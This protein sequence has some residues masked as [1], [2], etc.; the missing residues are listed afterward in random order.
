VRP[1]AL[2]GSLALSLALGAIVVGHLIL[3]PQL[4]G[5]HVGAL[6]DPNLARALGEPLALRSSEILLASALVLAIV[7]SKWMGQRLPGP[8][9]LATAGLAAADRLFILPRMHEAW[10]RVDIVARRPVDHL[11]MAEQLGSIHLGMILAALVLLLALV[12]FSV[13][14]RPD[15]EA[16]KGADDEPRG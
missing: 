11:V 9:A 2:I 14:R 16:A 13:A 6:I 12:A 5:A 15:A 3:L 7:I 4:H 1:V 10:A 8:I